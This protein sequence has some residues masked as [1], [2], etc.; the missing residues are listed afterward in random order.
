[1]TLTELA[2][3]CKSREAY[4]AGLILLV[5]FGSF[6][7]GRLSKIEEGR[8]PVT[9]EAPTLQ[10]AS[11]AAV[12]DTG[13]TVVASKTGTKYHF[14]WCA[15]ASTIKEANKMSFASVEAAR[16]A[17]YTPASNCKGLK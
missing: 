4:T 9:I 10:T 2:E 13:G 8:T 11:V 6:G 12:V 15:G 5:G 1:M 14:P 3:K 17:G 16:K 7:L